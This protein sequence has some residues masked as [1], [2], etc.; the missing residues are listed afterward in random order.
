VLKEREIREH[1]E[2]LTRQLVLGAWD[3]MEADGTFANL[4]LGAGQIAGT[5]QLFKNPLS[6]L[7]PTVLGY[8]QRSSRTTPV[9]P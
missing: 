8:A 6:P 5:H 2:Y 3:R 1:G 4:G 7:C 9:P